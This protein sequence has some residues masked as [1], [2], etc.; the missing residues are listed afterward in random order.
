MV[1]ELTER[2]Q[3]L[4]T[5]LAA[6]DET[7]KVHDSALDPTRIAPVAAWA[8][9]YRETRCVS[10]SSRGG[11]AGPRDDRLGFQR[12]H[13]EGAH[14]EAWTGIPLRRN[15][16]GMESAFVPPGSSKACPRWHR[17]A[18]ARP[19]RSRQQA[20]LLAL[21]ASPLPEAGRPLAPAA[22][23]S[24]LKWLAETRA[25]LAHDL[26]DSERIQAVVLARTSKLRD[27]LAALDRTLTIYDPAIRPENVEGVQAHRAA[28]GKRGSLI[29][30]IERLLKAQA[31]SYVS[32][33]MLVLLLSVEFNLQFD[34]RQDLSRW[35]KNV[36]GRALRKLVDRGVVEREQ[37]P[38]VFA[39]KFGR[40]RWGQ[41]VAV[42]LADL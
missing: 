7:I 19:R 27:D 3:K 21:E 40:W 28:Y 41:S 9:K 33:E 35:S 15:P 22:T 39:S 34:T 8:G 36:V 31:P 6:L 20:R 4:Q 2:R 30:A 14:C 24:A 13:R 16:K 42:A 32:T 1:D 38:S 37:D 10:T 18:I 26:A 29:E 5:Q 12:E 25:R 11:A 17:R 23:P